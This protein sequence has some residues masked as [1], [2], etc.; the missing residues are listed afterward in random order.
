MPE[1][2]A[3]TA[4]TIFHSQNLL[5]YKGIVKVIRPIFILNYLI[6]YY[7]Y[8]NI[9][10]LYL[11]QYLIFQ[12]KNILGFGNG[13]QTPINYLQRHFLAYTFLVFMHYNLTFFLILS[14]L[15]IFSSRKIAF[16]IFI[17]AFAVSP[18]FI[19]LFKQLVKICHPWF[20]RHY[21]PFLIP[22]IFLTAS[23]GLFNVF[24]NRK[25][26]D[27]IASI[28]ILLLLSQSSPLLLSSSI[29]LTPNE[30]EDMALIFNQ[31]NIIITSLIDGSIAVPLYFFMI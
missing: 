22:F 8:T 31:S 26:R 7:Y 15:S 24:S 10:G 6:F 2:F 19:F 20:M 18:S 21:W 27:V 14:V 17:L 28:L 25:Y 29:V 11:Y 5:Y 13:I 1:F 3:A 30:L 16:K 12:I 9:N 4:R 23:I